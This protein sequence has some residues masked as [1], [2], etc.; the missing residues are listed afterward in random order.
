[1]ASNE[2]L[3][4]FDGGDIRIRIEFKNLN[5]GIKQISMRPDEIIKLTFHGFPTFLDEMQFDGHPYEI[6]KYDLFPRERL[7]VIHART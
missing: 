6:E 1:M 4:M 2:Y 7:M 5:I 3:D